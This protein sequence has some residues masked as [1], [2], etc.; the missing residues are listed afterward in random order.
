MRILTRYILREVT[1]HAVIGAAIFT[2]VLF[3]RYL[4]RI[5]ELVVRA[6]APLP[7]VAEIFFYTVPLALTYTIPMSV[8]VGILI[9][10]SRLAAD[11][12]ITAMRASG[13][14]VWDFGRVL[15][16]F[17]AGAWLLAL[18]NGLYVAPWSLASLG[19]LEDQLKGSQVSYEVQPRVFYE[20]F[21]K[22]VLYVQDVHGAQGGAVWNGVFLAD[23][24]DASNPKITLAQEGILVPEGQD[25][26]QLHLKDGSSHETDPAQADKYQISTFRQTDIPIEL[27]SSENKADEQ[28]PYKA[29]GTWALRERAAGVD[30]ATAR[31]YLIEFH[32]RFALPTAC[33][34]LAMVGIPLGLSSKKSG[35]S[36]GFVL[37]IVLVF[38]YYF[39]SLIGVSLAKQGRVSPM[40]GA[41]LANIVFFAAALFLLWQ[42]ERRPLSLSAIRLAWKRDPLPENGAAQVAGSERKHRRRDGNAF[43]RASTRRRVFSA[44]FPTLLDD[45][46]LRDFFLYLGMIISTFLVLLLVFTLFE[47]LGDILRNQTPPTVVAEYLLNVSPYLLYSVAPLIMLL[48]VLITFGLMNRSNEITAMKATGTS[49]YRIVTPVLVAAAVLAAGLFFADQFYLPHTNK[50]QEA[51][52]NQIKGKPPQTYLRPDRRWIFGQHNDIYYY[53]FFDA[54]RN[55]FANLTIFQIDP[56]SFAITERIH[57]ERA[58]WADSMSRWIYEQG[59]KR[60]LRGSAI[61]PDGYRTFD[62]STFPELSETPSYFKK[63]VKQYSEMNY[64]ELRRYIRDLQQ[65]GFD[66]VRLRVQL[67][68]KLSYPLITLIMA[69]LAVP[70][71]L[72]TAKKGAVTGVAVAVGIAVVYTVV[73]R[74]FEAM[75]DISQLPPALAAWSPDLI[76]ALVGAYLILKIPT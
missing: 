2:F 40:L 57:A 47:L 18:A 19:R 13:M 24:S 8:L 12:E 75:G 42:A 6:S 33:L 23:I 7:S 38:V 61:A 56:A 54:D 37:T 3:T 71:S 60:S 1:S 31:L 65:S 43:E 62:V 48:A 49:V 45:Y 26:L 63:E 32:N 11:S 51:L 55:Q 69:V 50:R 21:P 9:G 67:H 27:A 29:I 72:S 22:L 66:V 70:F 34:V 17:V 76:F 14:G 64:E 39:V 25:R 20:G 36:G 5:L 58:H 73:S 15:A 53:Q 10:L 74:L 68:R 35:K 59:W 46:V 41:W 28:V 16:I 52:H 4:G 30:A 44:S